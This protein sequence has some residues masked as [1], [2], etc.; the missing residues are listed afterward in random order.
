M[1]NPTEDEAPVEPRNSSCTGVLCSGALLRRSEGGLCP[2]DC[3]PKEGPASACKNGFSE[4]NHQRVPARCFKPCDQLFVVAIVVTA[5]PQILV[6]LGSRQGAAYAI[7]YHWFQNTNLL[8]ERGNAVSEVTALEFLY[9]LTGKESRVHRVQMLGRIIEH[10][11]P[12]RGGNHLGR[13]AVAR[14]K[15]AM[16]CFFVA[17]LPRGDVAIKRGLGGNANDG[18]VGAGGGKGSR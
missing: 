13:K 7:Q 15:I 18:R 5:C 1:Q 12:V 10:V 4:L 16:P 17:R 8:P 3:L 9:V 11:N 14:R 2:L 6:E